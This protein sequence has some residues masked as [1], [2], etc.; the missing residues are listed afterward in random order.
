MLN[1][2]PSIDGDNEGGYGS[3]GV[4]REVAPLRQDVNIYNKELEESQSMSGLAK[5]AIE[6]T[7][8]GAGAA[9]IYNRIN[10]FDGDPSFDVSTMQKDLTF[11]FGHKGYEYF[12]DSKS[13]EELTAKMS[14]WNDDKERHRKLS[15]YGIAGGVAQLTAGILDP[16]AIAIGVATEG[17]GFGVKLGKLGRIVSSMAVNAGANVAMEGLMYASDTQRSLDDI[18]M[19]AGTGAVLGAGFG[20]L[21]REKNIQVAEAADSFDEV[22][23]RTVKAQMD[24]DVYKAANEVAP[25]PLMVKR[26]TEVTPRKAVMDTLESRKV[27]R[28]EKKKA[29]KKYE[30]GQVRHTAA[31]KSQT[32]EIAQLHADLGVRKGELDSKLRDGRVRDIKAKYAEELNAS[33]QLMDEGEEVLKYTR[34]SVTP[35]EI[36][37]GVPIDNPE[38]TPVIEEPS[39]ATSESTT[40]DNQSIGAAKTDKAT[41]ERSLFSPHE[42]MEE[43]LQDLEELGDNIDDSKVVAGTSRIAQSLQSSFATV[44]SSESRAARGL[45]S[46]LL[47]N[48]QG[49][50]FA[51]KTASILNFVY[52]NQLRSVGKNRWNEGFNEF[53][54]ETGVGKLKGYMSKDHLHSFN[55]KVHYGLT[56]GESVS[57]A[58]D[59]AVEGQREMLKEGLLLMKKNG[60]AGFENVDPNA[61]YFPVIFNGNKM[62]KAENVHG[63][64]SIIDT[65]K[66]GYMTGKFR[67]KENQAVTLAKMQ[68]LRSRN[69]TLTA[70][71]SFEK[72]IPSANAR[73]I[74]L[75]D[76]RKQGVE[77]EFIDRL[78]HNLEQRDIEDGVS[79][80]AKM[81]LGININSSTAGL[82]VRDLLETNVANVVDN[83]V[84]EAAGSSAIAKMGYKT[85]SEL[86][87]TIAAVEN[88]MIEQGINKAQIDREIGTL[89]TAVTMIM[90]KSVDAEPN[91]FSVVAA[92][93]IR[94][95]TGLVRLGQVGFAQSAELGRGMAHLGVTTTLKNVPAAVNWVKGMDVPELKEM[96]ELLGFIGEDYKLSGWNIRSD[97]LGM[98]AETMSQLGETFDRVTAAGARVNG[99]LSGFNVIQGGM[100]KINMRGINQKLK[101]HMSGE[102]L[103]G[104]GMLSEIGFT[105]E[106]LDSVKAHM[107][108]N[109][110]HERYNGEKVQL[111]NIDEMPA[112]M[113]E[114]LATGITRL[115]GRLA[116]KNFIGE[117]SP[118]VNTALGKVMTQFKTF[119]IVS[120]EK[121][122]LHDLRG[123][124]V[125]AAQILA[126]SGLI[127]YM[128]YMA[129]QAVR[130]FGEEDPAAFMQEQMQGKNVS[131][132]IW[133][134][135][136]QTASLSLAG[137]AMAS[138]GLLPD[139]VVQQQGES[140]F[141]RPMK[142]TG[143]VVPSLGIAGDIASTARDAIGLATGDDSI[144]ARQ[145]LDK[146]RRMLPLGNAI[147]TGQL[148]QATINNIGE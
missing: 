124:K 114:T 102:E 51:G 46:Q 15:E 81:S 133:N 8:L 100:E 74:F 60:V 56:T 85:P 112:D 99:W 20:A 22:A 34:K 18:Y 147:G 98:N 30:E 64:M 77:D 134:K 14:Y 132:G 82:S 90:G 47:E 110:K 19:A 83:Y 44:A 89:K 29:K 76:L 143:D 113:Q 36:S 125:K 72:A 67:L 10:D 136:P 116:Q 84:K 123:D 141:F 115:S 38:N 27:S 108:A 71:E 103:L 148:L 66:D 54:K 28:I 109:P 62:L 17:I 118:W 129:Q 126:Y 107:D 37:E 41:V 120:A 106:F 12:K 94:D 53:L 16:T 93:R 45:A 63:E 3:T 25:S 145:T 57:P 35:E 146:M 32:D 26:K 96:Q 105:T 58:V 13:Q 40:V 69:S 130:S 87:S 24:N 86:M 33:K 91:S 78:E 95:W 117:T 135:L 1:Q 97:E 49:N 11:K 138:F 43:K 142:D 61:N 127:G 5:L 80:R 23:A 144:S 140:G 2:V 70:S 73:A 79:N 21:S 101:K 111:F 104:D 55:D 4:S 68:L 131:I 122:L 65:L 42:K 9:R 50:Q 92:R 6:D 39:T 52:E 88:D 128:T 121:Q 48:P 119:S 59:K 31:M 75:D 139:S 137:D 7:W